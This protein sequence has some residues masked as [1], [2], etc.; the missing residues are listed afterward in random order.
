LIIQALEAKKKEI[1]IKVDAK[2]KNSVV[3]NETTNNYEYR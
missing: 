1:D 3:Y 2:L